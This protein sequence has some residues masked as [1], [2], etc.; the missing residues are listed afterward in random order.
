MVSVM[1]G[2]EEGVGGSGV[3]TGNE[4]RGLKTGPPKLKGALRG[5]EGDI[6]EKKL[7]SS[8]GSLGVE[9]ESSGGS[10]EAWRSD[11]MLCWSV[12]C[13]P[14]TM[15]GTFCSSET[16]NVFVDSPAMPCSIRKCSG[17]TPRDFR[18][19]AS[20]CSPDRFAN[21]GGPRLAESDHSPVF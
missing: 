20:E 8:P 16:S 3:S 5:D 19:V 9:V 14:G 21:V 12:G 1:E 7:V 2:V 10:G 18:C 13:S 11:S 6:G 17:R 15:T 4:G